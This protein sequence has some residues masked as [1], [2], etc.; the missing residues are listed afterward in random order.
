[1]KKY[2]FG[3]ILF[4]T[5]CTVAPMSGNLP[6]TFLAS[7]TGNIDDGGILTKKPCGPPCFRNITVGIT[8]EKDVVVKIKSDETFSKCSAFDHTTQSGVRGIT[9]RSISIGFDSSDIVE[10]ILFYP[11]TIIMLSQV[12]D[13]YG[14]P[15]GVDVGYINLTDSP[16]RVAMTLWYSSLQTKIYLLQDGNQFFANPDSKVD[17]VS[18]FEKGTYNQ[19]RLSFSDNIVD[20]RGYES[21][22]IT[23]K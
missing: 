6:E 23:T 17:R 16:P 19:L 8:S 18:Y 7:H 15:D 9:C 5:A 14:T 21:Y 2:I 4:L 20:W 10:M 3:L 22:K 13:S 1:M 12:I 11:T